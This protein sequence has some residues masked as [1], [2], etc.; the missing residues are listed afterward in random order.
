M[1]APNNGRHELASHAMRPEGGRN[2]FG[3]GHG[4]EHRRCRVVYYLDSLRIDFAD[5]HA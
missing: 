3:R 2:P 1:I 5:D 4:A